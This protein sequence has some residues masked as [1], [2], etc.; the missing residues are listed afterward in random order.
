MKVIFVCTGNA[1]RSPMAEAIFKDLAKNVEVASAGTYASSNQKA[2]P[3]AVKVCEKYGLDLTKHSSR[4]INTLK[5][6]YDDLI[7][8]ASSSHKDDLMKIYPNLEIYT[9]KE[10][11]GCESVDIA[12]PIGGDFNRYETCFFEIKKSLE[13]IVKTHDF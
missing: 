11:A 8:T 1:C 13:K 6:D 4:N 5:I 2:S 10:Y 7:L 3:Y 12:D 9:I